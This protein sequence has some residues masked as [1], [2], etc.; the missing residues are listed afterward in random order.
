VP[1]ITLSYVDIAAATNL[2]RSPEQ[3]PVLGDSDAVKVP[4]KDA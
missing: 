1:A 4:P 2:P 3:P